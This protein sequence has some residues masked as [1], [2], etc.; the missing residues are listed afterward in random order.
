[1]LFLIVALVLCL[2][3]FGLFVF[4]SIRE[5]W[6]S[7]VPPGLALLALGLAFIVIDVL[8]VRGEI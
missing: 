2:L 7:L 8:D 4:Q 6:A 5:N 3:A 1:M